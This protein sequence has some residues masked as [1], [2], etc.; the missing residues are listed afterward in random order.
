LAIDLTLL[1]A[2]TYDLTPHLDE[3][4]DVLNKIG[5]GCSGVV[6]RAINRK[7][8]QEV[9]L[10]KLRPHNGDAEFAA[11]AK[12]EFELL[13]RLGTHPNIIGVLDFHCFQAE[14]ALVLEFFDGLT[15]QATVRE[16]VI[17]ESTANGLSL[18]LL[19]A[20]AHLHECKIVHRDIK[21]ENVLVSRCLSDLRLIDFNVAACLDDGPALTP[22]GTEMYKAPEVLLGEPACERSDVWASGLCIFYMLSGCLPQG[23]ELLDPLSLIKPHDAVKAVSFKGGCWCGITDS[24]KSM[25]HQC[26]WIDRETRPN[27]AELLAHVWFSAA[28][29]ILRSL[30]LLSS[31]V[32]GSE[33]VLS[34]LP[35]TCKMVSEAMN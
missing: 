25:L 13:S 28:E 29:H 27:V 18:C 19:K 21:P 6:H 11:T 16:K 9:A 35:Y 2:K 4:Y 10:K 8:G 33:G 30:S 26:L 12:K 20:V 7:S 34:V 15:L 1:K 3:T 17:P 23:R 31:M 14:A 22:T 5:N 24:C 32:P